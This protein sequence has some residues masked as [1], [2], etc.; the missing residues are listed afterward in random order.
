MTALPAEAAG[1]GA[2]IELGTDEVG[3]SGA[4]VGAG[5]VEAAG[6]ALGTVSPQVSTTMASACC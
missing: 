6:V 2:A 3:A 5:V 4:G 1:A